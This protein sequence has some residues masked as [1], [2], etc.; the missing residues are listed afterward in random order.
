MAKPIPKKRGKPLNRSN[1]KNTKLREI[2]KALLIGFLSKNITTF[3]NKKMSHYTTRYNSETSL[4]DVILAI[5][6]RY[7]L[8]YGIDKVRVKEAWVEVV[9]T[10][11]VKYTVS[12]RLQGSRLYVTLNNT[13]LREDLNYKK[14][15]LVTLLNEYLQKEVVKD[16]VFLVA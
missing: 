2:K 7:R 5:F 14:S 16:I 1:G 8:N 3:V 10:P 13:G 12:V 4:K 9:G 6:K 11:I 15:R